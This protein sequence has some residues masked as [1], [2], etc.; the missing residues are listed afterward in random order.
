MTQATQ[1]L[2]RDYFKKSNLFCVLDYAADKVKT[3]RLYLARLLPKLHCM[4]NF[5]DDDTTE[6]DLDKFDKTLSKLSNKRD[7]EVSAETEKAIKAIEEMDSQGEELNKEILKWDEERKKNEDRLMLLEQK[8]REENATKSEKDD[9]DFLYKPDSAANN[10]FV[11][12][13]KKR[14]S[15]RCSNNL[16]SL[17][18]LSNSNSNSLKLKA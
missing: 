2:S 8:E 7:K 14:Y 1:K 18:M 16:T 15:A 5:D 17:G 13:Y 3:V 4:I 11:H 9:F 12:H 6:D 10:N